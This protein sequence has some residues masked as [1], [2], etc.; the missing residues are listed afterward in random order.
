MAA[1]NARIGAQK[2]LE[3][4]RITCAEKMGLL[5][6]AEK[7]LTRKAVENNSIP[8][9]QQVD[10][11]AE[12]IYPLKLIIKELTKDLADL[13]EQAVECNETLLS[14]QK[15]IDVLNQRAVDIK[16]DEADGERKKAAREMLAMTKMRQERQPKTKTQQ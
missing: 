10:F 2:A 7:K 8:A 13:D 4:I 11:Y 1:T 5:E 3:K 9:D 14:S 12:N 16:K 6:S 15:K